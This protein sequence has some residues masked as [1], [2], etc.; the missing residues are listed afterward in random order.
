MDGTYPASCH[1][2]TGPVL[3]A[4]PFPEVTDLICRLP[5]PTLFYRLE[6]VHLG[7]LLRISVR[8]GT[9]INLQGSHLNICYY[10]QD[11][12]QWKLQPGLRPKPSTPTTATLLLVATRRVREDAQVGDGRNRFGPPPEFPLAS[13]CSGI[14]HHLSGPNVYA[15]PPPHCKQSRRGYVGEDTEAEAKGHYPA[16][17]KTTATLS[18]HTD[19]KCTSRH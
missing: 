15:L 5:L 11:L 10:H 13:S 19:G 1:S 8:S 4:N 9:K 2:P 17:R 14:V 16:G 7:D 18:A 6:A 3:R 12:H